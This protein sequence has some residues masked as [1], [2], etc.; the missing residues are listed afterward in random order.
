MTTKIIESF[1]KKTTQSFVL[2]EACADEMLRQQLA[3]E[4]K[5]HFS[6][7]EECLDYFYPDKHHTTRLIRFYSLAIIIPVG[8]LLNTLACVVFLRSKLKKL[9]TALYFSALAFADNTVLFA[10]LLNWLSTEANRK[11]YVTGL[12]FVHR[13]SAACKFVQFLRYFGWLLSAWLV[14]TICI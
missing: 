4:F 3:L 2:E 8:L 7:E 9:A 1:I 13:I 5:S 14:V 11:E 12:H 10:E 6:S